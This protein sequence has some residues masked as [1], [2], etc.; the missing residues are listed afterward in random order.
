[1]CLTLCPIKYSSPDINV[2]LF[3]ENS[4]YRVQDT[5]VYTIQRVALH[6]KVSCC[7]FRTITCSSFLL[8]ILA[9][10]WYFLPG[11]QN[12]IDPIALILNNFCICY[13]IVRQ[14]IRIRRFLLSW[15]FTWFSS[16]HALNVLS[17]FM[18]VIIDGVSDYLFYGPLTGR[19]TNNY[20]TIAISTLYGS[21]L[22]K[23]LSS[24]CYSLHYPFPLNGF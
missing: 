7:I 17:R 19:T 22:H 11:K 15:A 6:K 4:V 16:T 8:L 14:C 5:R 20:N 23:L 21:L 1:M 2:L 10:F 24:V 3:L 12:R 13:N 18:C 9:Y